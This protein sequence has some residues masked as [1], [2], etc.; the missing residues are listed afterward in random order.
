MYNDSEKIS[1]NEINKYSFCPYQW[2]YERLYGAK[3][4]REKQIQRNEALDLKDK[5]LSNFNKG[6]KFHNYY[7]LKRPFIFALKLIFVVIL[8]ILI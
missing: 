3:Y 1:A 5:T 7:R 6:I 2:Y 8:S 4:I